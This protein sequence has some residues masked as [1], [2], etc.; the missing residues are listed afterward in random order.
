MNYAPTKIRSRR[1]DV[2]TK[3]SSYDYEVNDHPQH[4]QTLGVSAL[5]FYYISQTLTRCYCPLLLWRLYLFF[6][7]TTAPSGP[8]PPHSRGF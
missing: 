3:A 6:Y 2:N 4:R 7:G 1:M 5:L 8:G